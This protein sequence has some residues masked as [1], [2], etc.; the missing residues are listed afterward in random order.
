MNE[1]E[2][3]LFGVFRKFVSS[4]NMKVQV[5]SHLMWPSLEIVKCEIQS[6]SSD[7]KDSNDMS[8]PG[9]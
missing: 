1:I 6:L 7:F 9:N 4:G 8:L 5:P 2:I 3:R